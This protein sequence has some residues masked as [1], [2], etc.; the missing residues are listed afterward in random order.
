MQC[1]RVYNLG[2]KIVTEKLE[3]EK[4]HCCDICNYPSTLVG[5][6]QIHKEGVH[7]KIKKVYMPFL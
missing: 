4:I 2:H 5:H 7:E 1:V 3:K 6:L